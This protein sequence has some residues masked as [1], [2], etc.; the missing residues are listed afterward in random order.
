M[1]L[2]P[3]HSVAVHERLGELHYQ[4]H[5]AKWGAGPV[6]EYAICVWHMEHG[7][8]WFPVSQG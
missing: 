4:I 8:G 5:V 7:T 2:N 3:H 6:V 1:Y